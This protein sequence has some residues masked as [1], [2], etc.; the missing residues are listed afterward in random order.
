[1]ENWDHVVWRRHYPQP[2]CRMQLETR[3][4]AAL[5]HIEFETVLA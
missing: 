4:V 2:A 5:A 1:M 3:I